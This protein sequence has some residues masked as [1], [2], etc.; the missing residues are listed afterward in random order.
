MNMNEYQNYHETKT[1]TEE[2]FPYNTYLCS[3]PRSF[4]RV[5]LHWHG[6]LELIVIK[7]GTGTVSVDFQSQ[8][9]SAGDIV[10]ALP[11]Q[12]HAI[13]QKGQL[14][15]DYENILFDPA[16]L[17]SGAQDLC[18]ARYILPLIKRQITSDTF[19]TPSLSYYPEAS[20]C[21]R[22]IDRLCDIRPEGYQL[23]VKGWL[24]HF[25][26]YLV[27]N[28]QNRDSAAVI[29]AKSLEK[30][31]A[32]L[33]HVEEHYAEPLGIEDMAKLAHYSKSHF[34]KY[35][36]AHMGMG[37]TEYLNHYRMTIA[38]R[39]LATTEDSILEVAA[40]SGFGNLSYF[41]RL[42]RRQ[43]GQTPG[44]FRQANTPPQGRRGCG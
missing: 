33:K 9:V 1:H 20:A 17:I 2:D 3:I 39:L 28:Q 8:T 30:L 22:E 41:N 44:K 29:K 10:L 13:E 27:Q 42:F 38:A 36:K 37:F 4:T 12:L 40:Q 34:M 6:E 24:F 14:R 25:I 7:K 15:M 31:K 16:M 43:F 19:L 35:F 11:G 5:P 32:I 18:A 26:F 21:I 23:A